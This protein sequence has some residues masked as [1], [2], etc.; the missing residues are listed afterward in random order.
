MNS[1]KFLEIRWNSSE[2]SRS[3]ELGTARLLAPLAHRDL[4]S[5][6]LVSMDLR[7]APRT[8]KGRSPPRGCHR[9]APIT[10]TK[11]ELGVTSML[12]FYE[13]CIRIL[14]FT[15]ILLGLNASRGLLGG[16]RQSQEV[17]GKS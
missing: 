11:G 15:M 3:V 16:P 1:L 17:L 14:D 2:F 7:E 13:D 8:A 4:T 9:K 12:G 6:L 5:E 10:A